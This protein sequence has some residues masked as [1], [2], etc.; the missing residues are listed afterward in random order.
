MAMKSLLKLEAGGEDRERGREGA[1]ERQRDR[2]R[3]R[4]EGRWRRRHS[5]T[6]TN[7]QGGTEYRHRDTKTLKCIQQP[8][9]VRRSFAGGED[10]RHHRQVHG[11]GVQNLALGLG[12]QGSEFRSVQLVGCRV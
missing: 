3:E 6:A 11:G 8:V 9:M 2:K 1:R 7:A 5:V 12:V 10:R 4:K